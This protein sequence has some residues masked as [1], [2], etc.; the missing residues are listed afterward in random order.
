M[1]RTLVPFLL[2]ATVLL[3]CALPTA[4]GSTPPPVLGWKAAF[5]NGKGFGAVKPRMVF[6]GGD[7][8]GEVSSITWHHWGRGRTVGFGRGWCPGRSVASGHPCLAALHVSGLGTC[9]GRRAY[10][11]LAF[12]FKPKSRWIAGS[13]WNVCSGP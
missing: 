5:P 7:P 6:L 4:L 12:N 11:R 10:R 13:S 2:A 1:S 9:H 3:A 8:T